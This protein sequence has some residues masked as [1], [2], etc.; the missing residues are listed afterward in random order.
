MKD[1][2]RISDHTRNTY[3]YIYIY[4]VTVTPS[5]SSKAVDTEKP[6]MLQLHLIPEVKKETISRPDLISH[7]A[8]E[9]S[10]LG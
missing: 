1:V 9:Q 4:L 10:L 3:I 5:D 7:L 6:R 2:I 8:G